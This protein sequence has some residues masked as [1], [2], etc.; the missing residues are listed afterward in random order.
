M[1]HRIKNLLSGPGFYGALALCILAVGVGGYFLLLR[2]EPPAETA[3]LQPDV[4]A[5][6]PVTDLPE[7]EPAAEETPPAAA[8]EEPEEVPA[9]AVMPEAPVVPDDTPVA[10]DEP[11]VVVSPLQGEVAA[12]FSV[13]A[14]L[15]DE[16]MDDWRTHDGLDIAAAAGDAV[17]AASAGTVLSVTDDA[18]MG[19][20]V[21]IGHGGGYETTY[22]SLQADPPVAEGESVSA[23]QVI[24]AVGATAA[25]EAAQGPH[26]HFAVTKDGAAVAR[27]QTELQ[28]GAIAS[29]REQIKQ[30]DEIITLR[31][32]IREKAGQ[33]VANGTETVNEMLRDI[34]AVS[35]AQLAKR[36]H[37]IQLLQE[38]YK[39][40]HL[41]NI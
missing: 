34:N 24:G 29:L 30:D 39:V 31:Q 23:G 41:N 19:T 21:V 12:V 25:A 8:A 35:D 36:L 28:S 17:L 6:S 32:R 9:A 18:L 33:R 13:D 40:K 4:Q 3:V 37:E 16:T 26:L 15:Y 14:L 11:M 10:A 5:A 1:E 22:A 7:H 27:L 2:E 38:I 20:T